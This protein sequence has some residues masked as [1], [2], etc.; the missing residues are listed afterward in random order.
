M[1]KSLKSLKRPPKPD[2]SDS[3]SESKNDDADKVSS[4]LKVSHPVLFREKSAPLKNNSKKKKN[5]I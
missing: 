3:E 5:Y 2:D 4:P 1:S